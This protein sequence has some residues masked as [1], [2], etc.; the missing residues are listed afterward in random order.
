[1]EKK[2]SFRIVGKT[3]LVMNNPMSYSRDSGDAKRKTIPTPEDEAK[4]KAYM[5]EDGTLYAKGEWFMG[6]MRKAA[7]GLKIGKISAKVVLAAGF[8]VADETMPLVHPKTKKP[9]KDYE[10]YVCRAVVQRQGVLRARPRLAEWSCTLNCLYDDEILSPKQIFQIL[11]QAGKISGVGDQ[12][13]GAPSTP[14]RY[15]TFMVEEI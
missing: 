8:Q 3:P 1:M 7:S 13:P 9:L 11:T 14:G 2:I 15:G 10:I 4:S 12:R 6:S 5:N